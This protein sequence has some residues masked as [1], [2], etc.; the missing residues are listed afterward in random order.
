MLAFL[1]AKMIARSTR[2]IGLGALMAA[3]PL[4]MTASTITVDFSIA[5][6]GLTGTGDFTYDP[7]GISTAGNLGPYTDAGDG[8]QS[9]ELDY[10]GNSYTTANALDSPTLPTVFLP[11]NDT[12][13]HGLQY[14]V[15]GFWV[16]SGT[17]TSTGTAGDY[18]CTG[19]GGVG[20]ATLLGLGRSTEAF[21]A[22]GVTEVSI[23]NTGSDLVYN[24][25]LAPDITEVTGTVLSETVTPEPSL[26]SIMA[27][28][29][30]GLWF[31]RRRQSAL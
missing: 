16:V 7:S 29:F 4:V 5:L 15:F 22:S 31:A 11:G 20:D 6:N 21:L 17:C 25:G 8:L 26:L 1:S 28:G 10:D 12:L 19:P 24:L 18:T 14:E 23:G 9:F 30:A 13:Q 3:L 2:W 27:L